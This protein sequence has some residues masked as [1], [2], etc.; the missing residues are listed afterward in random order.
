MSGDGWRVFE[1][2][3]FPR[4]FVREGRRCQV[5][6]R[7]NARQKYPSAASHALR[8]AVAC[9]YKGWARGRHRCASLISAC[10]R[11]TACMQARGLDA[12]LWTW[13]GRQRYVNPR[14]IGFFASPFATPAPYSCR[15]SSRMHRSAA[16]TAA[17]RDA[18]TNL[19]AGVY[20]CCL[21]RYRYLIPGV[22]S[23][24]RHRLS[25]ETSAVRCAGAAG[26][27]ANGGVARSRQRR[28]TSVRF[29]IR[30]TVRARAR[31]G[32]R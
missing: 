26:R 24:A 21:I 19:C 6:D 32:R 9:E 13:S 23:R 27:N 17:A 5:A 7:R 2:G 25:C 10:S 22:D 3:V 12:S 1:G 18:H 4:W 28:T 31:R 14:H 16:E 15:P 20:S 8:V 29:A 30:T 11:T